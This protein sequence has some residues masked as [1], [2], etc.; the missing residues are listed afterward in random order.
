MRR[1]LS[2]ILCVA[3]ISTF[4]VGGVGGV[5]VQAESKPGDLPESMYLQPPVETC[6]S[7]GAPLFAR[8]GQWADDSRCYTCWAIDRNKHSHVLW[9][10][11]KP[12]CLHCED[13]TLGNTSGYC[14]E[15]IMAAC[16][17]HTQT[18]VVKDKESGKPIKGAT[19]TG[20]ALQNIE[21]DADG[22]AAVSSSHMHLNGTTKLKIQCEGYQS[23]NLE[24][25]VLK[26]SQTQTVELEKLPDTYTIP[27]QAVEFA[28][29][30][31]GPVALDAAAQL[32]FRPLP[33][34]IDNLLAED[35]TVKRDPKTGDYTGTIQLDELAELLFDG[36]LTLTGD[37]TARWDEQNSRMELVNADINAS[38][39]LSAD[40]GRVFGGVS[41][42][43]TPVIRLTGAHDESGGLTLIPTVT[44]SG[45]AYAYLGPKL[46]YTLKLGPVKTKLEAAVNGGVE[47]QLWAELANGRDIQQDFLQLTG[48]LKAQVKLLG[49]ERNWEGY[50]WQY[51]P[52]VEEP[53]EL[54]AP[55]DRFLGRAE[56]GTGNKDSQKFH[57]N[58]R[59]STPTPDG[60]PVVEGSG[61]QADPVIVPTGG[62]TIN[63]GGV[64]EGTAVMLWIQDAT[65]REDINRHRLVYA[66][67]DGNSW[68]D[69]VPVHDDGTADFAPRAFHAGD[70]TYILWQSADKEFDGTVST[71][72]Y[73]LSMDLYAAVLRDGQIQG[74]TNLSEGI[75]GYCGMHSL[76]MEDGKI[77]A[78]WVVNK[79]G[80]LLF[81]QGNNT[82]Y[83]A[84]YE[85]NGWNVSQTELQPVAQQS[86]GQPEIRLLAAQAEA[87]G[88]QDSGVEAAGTR[89]YR[90]QDSSLACIEKGEE[91]I[92]AADI[93]SPAFETVTLGD[94]VFL[95]WL[96]VGNDGAY[97]LDGMFYNGQTGAASEP[98]TYLDYGTALYDVSASMDEKG[99]VLLAYQSSAWQDIQR[100]TY[101]SS[102]LMTAA[103]ALP[104]G[105][106]NSS[107]WWIWLVVAGGIVI[108]AGSGIA[109]W[110]VKRTRTQKTNER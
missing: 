50:H 33:V 22:K 102:D 95:Y 14:D 98:Q 59:P 56:T 57:P 24:T 74:V 87:D 64:Y 28:A 25:T 36:K 103:I 27:I 37:V 86:G 78:A 69:P 99:T 77:T 108:A 51:Y 43:L 66:W 44:C 100:G 18:V 23:Q 90:T 17:D 45:S 73:A 29:E 60:S 84:V 63:S 41:G 88:E 76:S 70:T 97:Q 20:G 107:L 19:V 26:L 13:S 34:K 9:T 82:G 93:Q 96:R 49:I 47:F 72:E 52:V 5:Q 1:I 67:Y 83:T 4:F 12:H 104:D 105:L 31:F 81:S 7:C 91:R 8:E 38:V 94:I 80:D 30:A 42:E 110:A 6:S 61:T 11:P 16:G 55:V 109:V 48:N 54:P 46:E 53:T 39:D 85:N 71:E 21:T 75:D 32:D 79:S 89:V 65:E 58:A 35:V 40:I 62:G 10:P 101:A 15:C 92:L 3:L 68:S 106:Q 2:A